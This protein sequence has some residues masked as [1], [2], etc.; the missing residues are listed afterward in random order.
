M[1]LHQVERISELERQHASL[2]RELP[3]AQQEHYW[4][5]HAEASAEEGAGRWSIPSPIFDEAAFR[6]NLE[7]D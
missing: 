4:R 3:L 2:L 7:E 1:L 6:R 5:R